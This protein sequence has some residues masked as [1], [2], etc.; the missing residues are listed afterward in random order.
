MSLVNTQRP[1]RRDFLRFAAGAL[2]ALP[3]S[4]QRA[5]AIPAHSPSG[6]I[7]DIEH[8]VIFMQENRSF[9]HYYGTMRGVRGF[10]DRIVVPLAGGRSVWQQR[11]RMSDK[12]VLPFHLDTSKTRAQCVKSLDHGWPSGHEAWNDGR[13]D[14]W[15][16]AKGELTMGHYK[17]SDIPFQFALA[18]AFTIC[19]HYFCSVMGPTDPN[20][21]YHWTG[22]V[23]PPGNKVAAC[24][25]NDLSES[26][27][28]YWTT[29]PERLDKAG[30]SWR[31]YQKGTEN[32]SDR[33]FE[34]NYGD[35]PLLFFTQYIHSAP[36]SKLRREAMTPHSLED[37]ARDVANGALPQV[38]WIVSPEAY[39]EHPAW[40]PAYGAEY[41]ARVLDALTANP[42]VW[43]KTVLFIN[44]DEND[45]YFDHVVPP[46]PPRAANRGKS[47]VDVSDE[48]YDDPKLGRV[49]Y[50]L[51]VRV[52]MTVVS[53]WTRGGWVCSQVFDHTSVLRF[54]EARF[55]EALHVPYITRW[56]RAVCGDLT[57][58]FDFS[59]PNA[60]LP[61]L[62]DTSRYREQTERACFTL[63]DPAV[64]STQTMARQEP[65]VR[66]ARAIPYR[67]HVHERSAGNRRWLEFVNEGEAGAVFH[68]FAA[69]DPQGPRVYTV[70]ARK[71]LADSWSMDFD[72]SVF[73]PNGFFREFRG[74][75]APL[76]AR[77]SGDIA[78]ASLRIMLTNLG[79]AAC[80]V[81][82]RDNA[83]GN[84]AREVTLPTGAHRD[85]QWET[86]Q[87][88]R[89]YDLSIAHSLD[90]RYLRRF[91]GHME[92]AEPST[93]DPAMGKQL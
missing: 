57:A 11:S 84:A 41:T 36:D 47:T 30:I 26:G 82:I 86:A 43:S 37:L 70:E 29:F 56:R 79:S 73:G 22:T 4:I 59:K 28:A 51:G 76:A 42:E 35:N 21:I 33:P 53:P 58:A 39:S 31:V 5:L 93:S 24:I 23:N 13:Y 61:Q 74:S 16:D 7:R 8:I 10:G 69:D 88:E 65:G 46:T 45:G 62:P 81:T 52:P 3:L 19:D 60:S 25:D 48:L 55:G 67:L 83:Y 9:D 12:E 20:R 18:N 77:L 66:R 38:S 71:M 75:A 27:I 90:P 32:D 78:S 91:A 85:E 80:I 2:G 68:V 89:W 40:P 14:G 17:E 49:P 54:L 72:L 44:Y 63:P 50:G 34:G 6:T 92:T 87:S 64:P 15:I 1:G